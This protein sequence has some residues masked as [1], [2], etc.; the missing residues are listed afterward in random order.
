MIEHVDCIMKKVKKVS[1]FWQ[2]LER[3]INICLVDKLVSGSDFLYMSL[4]NGKCVCN[5]FIRVG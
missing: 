2:I 5:I 4:Q 3:C 1:D